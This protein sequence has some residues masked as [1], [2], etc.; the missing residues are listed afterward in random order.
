MNFRVIVIIFIFLILLSC[1]INKN[2][3][4][5]DLTYFNYNQKF[6]D[7]LNKIKYITPLLDY[8]KSITLI[9]TDLFLITNR[10]IIPFFYFEFKEFL[11]DLTD[12]HNPIFNLS[13][14]EIEDY[15]LFVAKARAIN[16]LMLIEAQKDNFKASN[17]EVYNR[18]LYLSDNNIEEFKNKLQETMFTY[19][20]FE[21]DTQ[22]FIILEKYKNE[23]ILKNITPT[24]EELL[25]Y[26][27]QNPSL[28]LVKERVIVRHILILTNNVSETEKKK[29]YELI[30]SIKKMA[31]EGKDFSELARKY[32]H[33]ETTKK[34][35]GKIG[36]YLER[37]QTF[38]EFEDAAF[39]TRE[40]GISDIIETKYGFH[41]LKV[42]KIEKERQLSFEEIKDKIYNFV[43]LEK[44]EQALENENKRLLEKYRFKIVFK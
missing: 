27:E 42:D 9:K 24:E 36:E 13:K 39:N 19:D 18:I 7:K 21:K 30:K 41:I 40:G 15:F 31:E 33:D 16:Q 28:S 20:F 43:R 25:I 11:D 32:S 44:E 1:N 23:K 14:K 17:D 4:E 26:Y 35:G 2:I 3:K 12:D 29:R 10:Y 38:K 5:L 6:I 8:N 34:A 37:G 22:E